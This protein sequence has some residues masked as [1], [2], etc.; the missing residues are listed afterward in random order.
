MGTLLL[1]F[2]Q[3]SIAWYIYEYGRLA[4]GL[5]VVYFCYKMLFDAINNQPAGSKWMW[6]F[7][8]FALNIVGA[9]LY[10]YKIKKP[11]D[12]KGGYL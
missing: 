8:I 5:L 12:A 3:D 4:I 1:L 6:V 2:E 7:I 9:A 10:Y 11:R